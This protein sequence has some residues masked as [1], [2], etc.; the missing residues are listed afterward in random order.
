[1]GVTSDARETVFAMIGPLFLAAFV[2]ILFAQ[3]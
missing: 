1:M 3:P 2:Y